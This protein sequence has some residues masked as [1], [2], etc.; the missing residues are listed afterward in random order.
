MNE[1]RR[2]DKGFTLVEL[3]VV[4]VILGIL[5]A[6]LAPNL[7]GYIDK[8]K[9]GK[10]LEEAH[11]V[12]TAIQVIEDEAYAKNKAPIAS[13]TATE[14]GTPAELTSIND[15]INPTVLKSATITFNT[16]NANK[17]SDYSVSTLD[18]TFVSQDGNTIHITMAAD[19]TWDDE[20]MTV[21]KKAD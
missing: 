18:I 3:I 1:K 7:I 15:L 10:Y 12:Y 14:T 11:S 6:V 16:T 20:G 21:T 2:A 4:L 8:A 17:P 19:G 13:L 9:N 5:A